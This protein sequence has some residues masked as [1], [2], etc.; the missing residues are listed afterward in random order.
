M[1]RPRASV[2]R[3]FGNAMARKKRM[4]TVIEIVIVKDLLVLDLA[5][6]PFDVQAALRDQRVL[7]ISIA[8]FLVHHQGAEIAQ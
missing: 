7:S 6:R 2:Q 4:V 3:Q 1:M 5:L 8:M